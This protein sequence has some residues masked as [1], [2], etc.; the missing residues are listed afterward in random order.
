MSDYGLFFDSVN[1]DRIYSA[2]S[3]EEWLKPF[4]KTGVFSNQL[5]VTAVT[6]MQVSISGGYCNVGGKVRFFN[7]TTTMTLDPAD[8]SQTR[9]DSIVIE[10]D[11]AERHIILKKV[12]GVPGGGATPRV[13]NPQSGVYQ[14]V[15]ALI[16]VEAGDTSITQAD[17]QDKRLDGDW[18]GTVAATVSEIDFTTISRQFDAFFSEFQTDKE[19]E[20][21]TWFEHIQEQLDDN[22]VANLQHQIDTVDNRITNNVIPLVNLK[23]Y[24]GTWSTITIQAS[25][26][27]NGVYSLESSYPSSTYDILDI[28]PF[29]STTKA[30]AK[31]WARA[32]CGGYNDTNII[33]ARGEV[34]TIDIV[35]KICVA[36]KND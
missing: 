3:M 24:Y 23:Q 25:G 26:W 27:S 11:D 35:L 10:R 29:S 7:E 31:A 36:P 22:I 2:S 28:L 12:N 21:D 5:A 4:F 1:G 34:P 9:I 32:S 15:L 33:V 6:G 17:I 16:T 19:D 14:L 13:W 20:F 30:Q 8:G 18:C